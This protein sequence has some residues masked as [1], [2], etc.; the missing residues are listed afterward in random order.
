MLQPHN[1]R[2]L[3]ESRYR[4]GGGAKGSS[5]SAA[6]VDIRYFRKKGNRAHLRGGGDEAESC[7][8]KKVEGVIG[9]RS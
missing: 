9:E 2:L 4:V 3:Y 5:D 1:G 6:E 8:R 7:W